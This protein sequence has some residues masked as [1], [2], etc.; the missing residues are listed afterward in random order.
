L[1]RLYFEDVVDVNTPHPYVLVY[2]LNDKDAYSPSAF[3]LFMDIAIAEDRSLL[4]TVF[5]S[6]KPVSLTVDQLRVN[7]ECGHQAKASPCPE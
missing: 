7:E 6:A 1:S 5:E 4:M 2:M 3:A